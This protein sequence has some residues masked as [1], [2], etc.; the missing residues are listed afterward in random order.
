MPISS[1]RVMTRPKWTR[2][3]PNWSM[4]GSSMG[5]RMIF[6]GTPSTTVPMASRNTSSRPRNTYRLS[7][8]SRTDSASACGICS[9]ASSHPM[10]CE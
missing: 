8:V 10:T 2:S 9:M 4:I 3:T 5:T 6:A 7:V 1:A